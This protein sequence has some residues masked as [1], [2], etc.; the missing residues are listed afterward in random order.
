MKRL[1]L[2]FVSALLFTACSHQEPEKIKTLENRISELEKQL[3]EV[4]RPGFGEMMSGIQVHHS[5]LWFAGRNRNW[6]LASFEIKELKEII[7]D[8]E[9]YQKDRKDTK[10]MHMIEPALD[11][12]KTAISA[13]DLEKFTKSY[14][15]LTSSCNECHVLTDFGYNIVKTPD[16]PPV[17]NQEYKLK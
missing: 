2:I 14:E 11:S 7:E 9:K 8:I 6:Q 17:G 12:V 4:Y 16:A 13:K 10:L 5:K 15:F 3:S 1:I